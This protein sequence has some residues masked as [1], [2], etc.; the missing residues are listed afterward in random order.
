M[1]V[2]YIFSPIFR[3]NPSFPDPFAPENRPHCNGL[4]PGW[5]CSTTLYFP[6]GRREQSSGP[7]RGSGLSSPIRAGDPGQNVCGAQ[8]WDI[9]L[10]R[11]NWSW[12]MIRAGRSPKNTCRKL[13]PTPLGLHAPKDSYGHACVCIYL[14]RSWSIL[15]FVCGSRRLTVFSCG[16]LCVLNWLSFGFWIE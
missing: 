8:I 10:G 11:S 6:F 3:N 15:F 2:K 5:C 14:I 7:T 13:E 1:I 4:T 12:F 9:L 16:K